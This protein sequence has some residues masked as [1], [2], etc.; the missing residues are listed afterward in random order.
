MTRPTISIVIATYRR[1]ERLRRC[2]ERTR[3][4][5]VEPISHEIVVVDGGSDDGTQDWLASQP[6][7]RVHVEAERG[8]SCRAYNIGFRMA[9]GEFVMWLNDDAWPERGA[10]EAGLRFL[11]RHEAHGVGMAA[12]YH[13]HQQPWNELH[14]TEHSGQHFG[15]LHVR[16]T[17]YANFGLL[18]RELLERVGYL[19]EGYWFCAWDPDLSL[20]VKREAGL[21]VAG[22]PGALIH[23]E[24]L[25]D[26]RKRADAEDA[27]TRDNERLFE[28][29]KLPGKGAFPDPR[30]AYAELMKSLEQKA[31]QG[32]ADGH[33]SDAGSSD[34]CAAGAG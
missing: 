6:E 13:T 15:L 28:K 26:E 21:L 20:K 32:A 2:I 1:L 19:D 9:R 14:G 8:G 12:F 31:R 7:L 33:G 25:A 30:P 11:R 3:A 18:R 17:P 10:V 23:H 24:E 27:R 16:G 29:W 22:C 5:F 4:G 34:S